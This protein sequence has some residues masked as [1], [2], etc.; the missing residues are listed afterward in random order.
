MAQNY[1][2]SFNRHCLSF[3]FWNKPGNPK[4]IEWILTS[5]GITFLSWI[6]SRQ[7]VIM[8]WNRFPWE[9]NPLVHIIID[10]ALIISFTIVVIVLI[11]GINIFIHGKS[12]DYWHTQKS[13]HIAILIAFFHF[14]LWSRNNISF[15]LM[16]KGVD[17]CCRYWRKRI[18]GRNLK[19]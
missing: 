5:V 15:F 2:N 14:Q 12:M 8:I 10:I 17:S 18:Y 19:H 9:K 6:V 4:F 7:L 13:I 11:F 3:Y 16:E 1:R